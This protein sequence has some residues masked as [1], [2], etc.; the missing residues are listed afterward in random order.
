MS[1]LDYNTLSLEE[2]AEEI[3][4]LMEVAREK[5]KQ[6][7]KVT[8]EEKISTRDPKYYLDEDSTD[9]EK[10]G[11]LEAFRNIHNSLDEEDFTDEEKNG[12][13]EKYS[14]DELNASGTVDMS[15]VREIA[16]ILNGD[17]FKGSKPEE[18][19]LKD[20]IGRAKSLKE[21]RKELHALQ[22]DKAKIMAKRM[23]LN[24]RAGLSATGKTIGDKVK[25]YARDYES[26]YIEIEKCN[27]A[28]EF[29]NEKTQ[30][31]YKEYC[32]LANDEING[33]NTL[34]QSQI[35]KISGLQNSREEKTQKHKQREEEI[36]KRISDAWMS[37]DGK[38][39]EQVYTEVSKELKEYNEAMNASKKRV[40]EESIKLKQIRENINI[41]KAEFKKELEEYKER[42]NKVLASLEG[43]RDKELARIEK[44]NIFKKIIGK[45]FSKI[46]SS[47]SRK[48][49]EEDLQEK[50]NIIQEYLAK[51]EKA[52]TDSENQ[53]EAREQQYER[54]FWADDEEVEEEPTW[55]DRF[56]ESRQE[57]AQKSEENSKKR[58]EA[59]VLREETKQENRRIR[60]EKRAERR[61]LKVERQNRKEDERIAKLQEEL[62]RLQSRKS[63]RVQVAEGR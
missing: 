16:G 57:I 47:K 50:Q 12:K 49:G 48:S 60:M 20:K 25:G 15:V 8:P 61:R 32:K 18:E 11:E 45:V 63:Y 2:I 26:R 44:Q 53:I 3:R 55:T 40:K 19:V 34:E 59:K 14:E 51:V 5:G 43:K 24:L 38:A 9:E 7:P 22:R 54:D 13:F 35:L 17:K 46:F 28:M 39:F 56:E 10:N 6:E 62:E 21:K 29:I 52:I 33:L 42:N 23:L 58:T 37:G 4:R 36:V 31:Y 27:A 30:K 41:R 1:E